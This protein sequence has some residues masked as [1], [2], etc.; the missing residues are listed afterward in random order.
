MRL[1]LVGDCHGNNK[2]MSTVILKYAL[3]YEIDKIVQLGDFGYWEHRADGVEFLDRTE[4]KLAQVGI[5]MFFLDGNHENH[6]LLWE[7]YPP[8]EEGFCRVREHLFYLPR[9]HR[10]T[11]DD[12]TFLS[13]G[14][15]Y[16]IDKEWRLAEE[17]EASVHSVESQAETLWWPTETITAEQAYHAKEGGRADVMLTHDS[18]WG[19]D[20]RGIKGE[21]WQSNENRRLL[22]D[23]VDT[24][25]PRWLFHG[26]YHMEVRD[27][28]LDHPNEVDGELLWERTNVLGLS[29][30]GLPGS[31]KIVDLRGDRD[32]IKIEARRGEL[33]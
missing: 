26:H 31:V 4:R 19:I 11:W 2:F 5:Q 7:R 23:V 22:R 13:L 28:F 12:V 1:L 29:F 30:E 15:A 27:R 16:S 10:W 9:G 32:L 6:P 24:V 25:R 14:G 20:M 3:R 17:F 33:A 18:P 21:F 8:N